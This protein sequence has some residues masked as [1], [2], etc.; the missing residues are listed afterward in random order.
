MKIHVMY[1]MFY[2]RTERKHGGLELK[3]VFCKEFAI[4]RL[5][6]ELEEQQW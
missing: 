2:R 3:A 4:N 1:V 5:L 6:K